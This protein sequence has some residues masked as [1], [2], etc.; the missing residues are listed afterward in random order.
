MSGCH[1]RDPAGVPPNPVQ[2]CRQGGMMGAGAGDRS[3]RQGFAA[4][5]AY[6]QPSRV[7][8]P[9]D[10]A[11]VERSIVAV[12]FFRRIERELD[13]RRA[14]IDDEDGGAHGLLARWR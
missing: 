12:L 9:I 5:V 13:A 11:L 10:L 1:E 3:I 8:D 7:T 6:T 4:G 2:Q 14:C